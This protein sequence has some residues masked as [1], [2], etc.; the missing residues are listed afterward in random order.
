MSL[1]SIFENA[2]TTLQYSYCE[3]VNDGRGY[4]FGFCGF[5]TAY[6]D[7]LA[8]VQS[9]QTLQPVNNTLAKYI[10]PM[11]QL[12]KR[13]SGNVSTLP[14]FCDAIA[15][16]AAD[17][18]FRTAQESIQKSWYYQP[19][20]VWG[21]NLGI[22]LPLVKAQLYDAMINHGEGEEDP[23]SID[24]IVANA[25]ATLGGTPLQGVDEQAWFRA[26]LAARKQTLIRFGDRQSTRRIDY[27]TKLADGGN[28]ALSGPIFI[29]LQLQPTGWTI[30]D[31]Y[32]GEFE[33]Y[34]MK[35]GHRL[36]VIK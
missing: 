15:V 31:V 11:V 10:P 24:F 23:F 35:P 30:N 21:K 17:P 13:E 16:A 6:D 19:S 18:L 5:T 8:V 22:T 34:D 27:Y 4:T 26:F 7:G 12:A 3:N 14:G 36:R 20:V 32:Y 9:Y 25:T 33:I 28:W 2:N 1:T 29:D